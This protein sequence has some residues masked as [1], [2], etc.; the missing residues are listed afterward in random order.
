LIKKLK[1]EAYWAFKIFHLH[2]Q[3]HPIMMEVSKIK[4][5]LEAGQ[6]HI[7]LIKVNGSNYENIAWK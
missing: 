6:S 5:K 4:S 7:L 1:S 3:K 2:I